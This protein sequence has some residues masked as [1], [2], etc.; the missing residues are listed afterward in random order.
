MWLVMKNLI[1]L[2]VALVIPFN[3]FCHFC[4]NSTLYEDE[5]FAMLSGGKFSQLD[6]TVIVEILFTSDLIK[7]TT[8]IEEKKILKVRVKVLLLGCIAQLQR[9]LED[10][11]KL[12]SYLKEEQAQT[13]S[14]DRF[15]QLHLA[16]VMYGEEQ[17]SI[18][19]R[20]QNAQM[21]LYHAL[22]ER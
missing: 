8:D 5:R 19:N 13:T 21:L 12:L 10:F 1:Y 7:Q 17:E 9:Q 15:Y 3:C 20:M 6:A 2:L 14:A 22:T 18:F 16:L 4:E 11:D